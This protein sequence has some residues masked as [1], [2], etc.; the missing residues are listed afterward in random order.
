MS[1]IIETQRKYDHRF[2]FDVVYEWEDI[3]KERLGAEY[4]YRGKV[5][6]FINHGVRKMGG[7]PLIVNI[8]HKNPMI[9]SLNKEMSKYNLYMTGRFADWEYYNMDAAI[10][11]AM[12]MICN[13][14]MLD[15]TDL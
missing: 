8:P 13:N 5:S 11:A 10:G 7:Q 3:I 15:K 2:F 1:L 4:Y 14:K 6:N 12:D 9:R